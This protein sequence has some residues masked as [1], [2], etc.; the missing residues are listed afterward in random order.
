VATGDRFEVAVQVSADRPISHLPLTLGFDPAL[1][2]V[3]SVAPGDFLGETGKAEVLADFSRPGEVVVGASRL[4]DQPGVTGAGTLVRVTFRA[5]TAGSALVGFSGKQALD[6]S[7]QP[8][9]PISVK[10]ARIEVQ[11]AGGSGGGGGGGG[12]GRPR[13]PEGKSAPAPERV[14]PPA[15]PARPAS[16]G[17]ADG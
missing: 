9:L 4:G 15:A 17:P 14:P 8:V 3:E 7:L 1:L 5:L 11:G 13:Q 12:G 6:S 16:A 2:A 10:P